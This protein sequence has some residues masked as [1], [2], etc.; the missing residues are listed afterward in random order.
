MN[1]CSR[2]PCGVCGR[3]RR[4]VAARQ[5]GPP[6]R[7][8]FAPAGRSRLVHRI[9]DG[10]AEVPD[11]DDRAALRRRQHEERV[12]EAGLARHQA[13]LPAQRAARQSSTRHVAGAERRPVAEQ[14]APARLDALEHPPAA[15]P[16]QPQLEPQPSADAVAH[17]PSLVE[18][19]ARHGDAVRRAR[20]IHAGVS[21]LPRE[22]GLHGAARV[23]HLARH[24]EP[25][26]APVAA[27]VLP[28]VRQLQRGAQRVRRSIERLV[29][30]A[31]DAQHEASDRIRRSPAV[32]E[33]VGPRGVAIRRGILTER[34]QQ[35]VEERERQI[36]RSNRVAE[37]REDE[38]AGHRPAA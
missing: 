10:A 32:V 7:H 21:C 29:A 34:A 31:G 38:V 11:G 1:G 25:P 18:S 19:V 9:V 33:H 6:E 36:E 26:G 28:E 27:E 15:E 13:A 24:V 5:L 17:R 4:I 14:R 8:R 20:V 16:G 35:I 2:R 37:R 30:V 23:E 22:V 3:R 12:V